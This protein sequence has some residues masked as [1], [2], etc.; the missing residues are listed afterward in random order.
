MSCLQPMSAAPIE[1][2]VMSAAP[3]DASPRLPALAGHSST[4][5]EDLPVAV[6]A[7][8]AAAACCV[9]WGCA[10]LAASGTL[11]PART[12]GACL[13]LGYAR[14]TNRCPNDCHRRCGAEHPQ[15]S[16]TAWFRVASENTAR[17]LIRTVHG[18]RSFIH[19]W[20]LGQQTHPP[21]EAQLSSGARELTALG[22]WPPLR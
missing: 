16:A 1:P 8:Q 10:A 15:P 7:N 12:T 5:A 3:P 13:R 18:H 9:T 20:K 2:A 19:D 6:A 14:Q 4:A 11:G 21:S 22:Y 17:R